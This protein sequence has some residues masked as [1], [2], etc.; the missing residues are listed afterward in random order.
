MEKA[1]AYRRESRVRNVLLLLFAVTLAACGDPRNIKQ[2]AS[3]DMKSIDPQIRRWIAE[4]EARKEAERVLRAK[5]QAQ[6]E[7]ALKAM[8]DAVS[9]TLVSK[10]LRDERESGM[11]LDEYLVL[12]FGY[13]NNTDKDISGVKGRIVVHDLFGDELSA[14]PISYDSVIKAGATATRAESRSVKYGL[15]MNRDRKLAGLPNDKYKVIWE[16]QLIV[17]SDGSTMKAPD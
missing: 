16:P 9:V 6:R 12:Q 5:L 11:V 14:F 4:E 8:R 15:N 17:F 2:S 7:A 13:K 1:E 3:E 10:R